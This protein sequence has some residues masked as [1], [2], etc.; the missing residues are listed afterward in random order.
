MVSSAK[1]GHFQL[2]RALNRALSG[3]GDIP[4]IDTTTLDTAAAKTEYAVATTWK[5]KPPYRIDFQGRTDDANDN[6]WYTI[7]DWEYIP[8]AAGSTGLIIFRDQPPTG[9]D[10]RVWYKGVH[11]AVRAMSDVIYEGIHPEQLIWEVVYRMYR[12]KRGMR[13]APSDLEDLLLEADQR[14]REYGL[15]HD[16]WKPKRRNKLLIVKHAQEENKFTYP[17]PA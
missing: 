3:I 16:M 4:L 1:W 6:E 7:M 13:D 10:I 2:I 8:A 15:E 5:R 12:W 11:P 9:R 14:R 17:G